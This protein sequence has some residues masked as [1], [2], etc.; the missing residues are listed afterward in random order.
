MESSKGICSEIER[1]CFWNAI[2]CKAST[3]NCTSNTINSGSNTTN[4]NDYN[5]NI[6]TLLFQNRK[7]ARREG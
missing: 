7:I 6:I 5:A 1:T 4:Y 2:N 3:T